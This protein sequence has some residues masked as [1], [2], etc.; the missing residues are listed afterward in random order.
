MH[1]SKSIHIGMYAKA[2]NMDMRTLMVL[3][4]LR[5]KYIMKKSVMQSGKEPLNIADANLET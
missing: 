5:A 2:N 1:F 3:N 4:S